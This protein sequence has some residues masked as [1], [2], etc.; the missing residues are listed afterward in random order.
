[1][2][3]KIKVKERIPYFSLEKIS[4]PESN[5]RVITICI[6]GFTSQADVPNESWRKLI[7]NTEGEIYSLTWESKTHKELSSFAWGQ[8]ERLVASQAF[9][10]I[11]ALT[12]A[13]IAKTVIDSY[14][15]NPFF[16]AFD[17]AV[18]SGELLGRIIMEIFPGYLI[19]L[20]AFSL[21]TELV[22]E[23]LKTLKINSKLNIIN[24][25]IL[26]GGCADKTEL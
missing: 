3:D 7:G 17:H 14:R 13:A 19:N 15:F 20:V 4:D 22:R 8:L 2:K 12:V 10:S 26:M 16:E 24:Q 21:G 23:T 18:F 1:M 9:F 6:S 11:P 5:S 25:V